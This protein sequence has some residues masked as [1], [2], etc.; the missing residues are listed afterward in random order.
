M[1]LPVLDHAFD[2]RTAIRIVSGLFFLPHTIAKLRSIRRASILFDKVGFR[3]ARPFVVFTS[4]LELIAA[5]G[6]ISGLYP[7]DGAVVA[8]V[9]LAGAAYAIGRANKLMWR[10]QHPGVEYMIFWAFV[11]LC[12]GFLPG[13]P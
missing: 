11:C 5:A 6:L 8:A 9:V 2:A 7:R 10:W 4:I 1:N 13:A 12:A 3:P